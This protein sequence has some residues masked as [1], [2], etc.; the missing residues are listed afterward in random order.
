MAP[1]KAPER[2]ARRATWAATTVPGWRPTSGSPRGGPGASRSATAGPVVG[3]GGPGPGHGHGLGRGRA[4][5]AVVGQEQLLE[6]GLP[7]EE[8]VHPRAGEG[9]DERLD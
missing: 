9:V 2:A 1:H 7:A 8:L 3:R 4:V 5:G 6:R